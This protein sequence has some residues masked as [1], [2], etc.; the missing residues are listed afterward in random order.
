LTPPDCDLRGFE[1]MPL[2]G[3]RLFTSATWIGAKP[4]AKIAA[5]RLWWHS[6]AKEVPAASLPDDDALLSEYAGYGVA[7]SQWRK[8]KAAALR[9]WIKCSDGRLYHKTV[10]EIALESWSGRKQSRTENDRKKR[11]RDDR[12]RMFSEL[13][14][15]GVTPSWNIKTTDL[16]ALH[17]KHVTQTGHEEN[18]TGGVTGEANVTAR[19]LQGKDS[20]RTGEDIAKPAPPVTGP[21]RDSSGGGPAALSA[22]EWFVRVKAL[23]D[24]LPGINRTTTGLAN[25]APLR[26][27]CEPTNGDQPCDW[28]LD[29]E[30]AVR[31]VAA[32]CAA[33]PK[34]LHSFTHPAISETARANRDRR[35]NPEANHARP[36]R[37]VPGSRP[38]D[39]SGA[40]PARGGLVRAAL[41]IEARRAADQLERATPNE[42]GFCIDHGFAED[43]SGGDAGQ[44]NAPTGDGERVDASPGHALAARGEA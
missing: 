44:E 20:D 9:G 29:V 22:T 13:S 32:S 28:E 8:V 16:R 4:D 33:G 26:S 19:Q 18:V 7:V 27:L 42:E 3:D 1:F 30:P 36:D 31:A 35:L 10:A 15:Q 17:A 11:E 41:R 5:L 14:E 40:R 37:H 21:E 24:T 2:F 23:V 25:I 39:A 34:P 6:Y 12:Q 38:S 43:R